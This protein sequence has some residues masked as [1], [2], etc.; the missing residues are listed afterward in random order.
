MGRDVG[1]SAST[2]GFEEWGHI[3][4]IAIY[5][6]TG[7]I[8]SRVATEAGRRGH[9][10]TAISRAGGA[11]AGDR[12][13]SVAG[14]AASPEQVAATASAHD[15]VVSAMG[16]TRAGGGAPE[17]FLAIVANLIANIGA[18]RLIVVGG[19]GSLLL[20][21]G[22]RLV[23]SPDFPDSYKPEALVQA[24]A[25][26]VLRGSTGLDWTYLSPAPEIAPG[27]RTG[28]YVVGADSPAGG[29]ISAEDYAVALVD[30]MERPA[31]SNRRF[32]VASI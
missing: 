7:M 16:P 1:L 27:E 23:D 24:Q 18:A 5:G 25:L 20:G 30:E 2:T 14:D 11:V 4:R 17:D 12:V 10:V 29:S 13:T 26:E 32:T 9:D 19:A 31:Y 22:S 21:D 8:G 3:M 6:G 28:R 15:V